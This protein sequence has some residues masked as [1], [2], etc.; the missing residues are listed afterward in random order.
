M[1]SRTL[2]NR[3]IILGFI[4]LVGF[5]LAKSIQSGSPLGLILAIVSLCASVYFLYLLGQVK[6]QAEQEDTI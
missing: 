1:L 6:K 2:I 5:S 4:V 3:F